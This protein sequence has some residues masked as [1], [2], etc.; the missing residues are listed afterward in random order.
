MSVEKRVLIAG[1]GPV[2]IISALLLVKQGIPVTLFEL[3]PDLTI[4]LRAGS[5]HPPSME[6]MEPIG[7]TAKMHEIGI[8]VPFWQFRDLHEGVVAEFDLSVLKNDTPYPYRLHIEQH[9][10]TRMA[11]ELLKGQPLAEVCFSHK[12]AGISQDEDGVE[13]TAETP[14]GARTFEGAY[15]IGADGGRSSVRKLGDFQFPGFTWPELFVVTST[16]YDFG[17]HGFTPNAYIADPDDWCAVFK[18]PGTTPEGLWRFAYG[19]DPALG[20]EVVLSGAEVEQRMQR[21][22]KKPEPYD[23]L[24]K[25]T[26]RV[27]QR[28]CETFRKGRVILAGDAAHI[29]NPI[30]ALGLNSGIQDAGNLTE[31]LGKVWRGEAGPELFDL[32]DRQRRTIANDIVQAMSTRNLERLQER[33]PAVRQ[34]SRE[35]MRR[36]REDPARH[37]QFLLGTSMIA[38]VRKAASI[39]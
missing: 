8:K 16:T 24:Y 4:D 11:Y 35:E 5:F 3:E 37:Y 21:F 30:G 17:K 28:V 36:V 1:A 33:D 13:I 34:K 23:I 22:V 27:H 15:L 2:G 12:V 38:S 39:T 10:V 26:Y 19:A 6:I 14:D 31:K 25:S 32:Y 9:R 7:V 29:N 18:M 20:D